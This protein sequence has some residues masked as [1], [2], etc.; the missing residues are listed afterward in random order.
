[1]INP[2]VARLRAHFA[3]LHAPVVA[4]NKSH[5]GSRLLAA[6]LAGQGIFMGGVLN[7]S[8][9]ALPLVP[10]ME[11][12]VRHYYPDYAPLWGAQ[13]W[14]DELEALMVAAFERH[15]AYYDPQRHRAWGWKLSE[16]GFILPVIDAVFPAARYVHLVRDG[17]DVAFCDHVAPEQP[18]W[19]KIYFNTDR[20]HEWRG[21]P[22]SH[23]AYTRSSHVYNALH[24]INSVEV[25]R[26]C[27]AMLRERYLQIRYEDLCVRFADTAQALL[28]FLDCRPDTRAL[29]ALAPTVGMGSIGKFRS[30][31]PAEQE[32]VLRLIEPT[33][34]ALGYAIE[35]R[36]RARARIRELRYAMLDHIWRIGSCG[37]A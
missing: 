32:E 26:M 10:V 17:R 31:P 22:L 20:I 3:A 25:A 13:P 11:Y 1:M 33:M 23:R 24:W 19:R 14:P 21:L 12:L 6:L 9:D 36:G 34:L 15:L 7:E 35:P 8:H 16:T 29:D 2:T 28:G 37:R 30:R 18:L 27:G 5:S 4:F